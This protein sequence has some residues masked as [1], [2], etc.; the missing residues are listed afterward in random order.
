MTPRLSASR[1]N[2]FL[3]CQH[4]AALWL[5]GAAPP[6]EDNE[7]LALIRTKGFEHEAV[8]LSE[9]EARLAP[10]VRI[11]DLDMVPRKLNKVGLT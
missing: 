2:S 3:G 4:S 9:L 10:A 7:A 11:P 1:L 5:A 8:V 6:Q